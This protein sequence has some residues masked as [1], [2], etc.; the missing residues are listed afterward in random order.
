[1]G[2]TISFKIDSNDLTAIKEILYRGAKLC[3]QRGIDYDQE[4]M[5]M[6]LIAAHSNGCPLDFRKLANA[7]DLD[8]AADLLGIRLHMNRETGKLKH[9]FR[10]R[11]AQ[12]ERRL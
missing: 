1:M 3:Q 9:R 11:C 10:P 4:D 7:P 2:H 5:S 6:D 8:F 12:N